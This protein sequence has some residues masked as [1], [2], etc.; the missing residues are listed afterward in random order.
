M[1]RKI[2]LPALRWPRVEA[3]EKTQRGSCCRGGRKARSGKGGRGKTEESR[4][5]SRHSWRSLR[6]GTR[7]LGRGGRDLDQKEKS[8]ERYLEEAGKGGGQ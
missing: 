2:S 3:I 6:G 1:G 5:C 4:R 7:R 8:L